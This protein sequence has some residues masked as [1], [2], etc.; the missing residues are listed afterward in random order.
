MEISPR[1]A[2]E[3]EKEREDKLEKQSNG[4]DRASFSKKFYLGL[5]SPLFQFLFPSPSSLITFLSPHSLSFSLSLNHDTYPPRN[6]EWF[7]EYDPKSQT[8]CHRLSL[9]LRYLR[10]HCDLYRRFP[11]RHSNFVAFQTDR[12]PDFEFYDL[13]KIFRY[14]VVSLFSLT[15]I[16]LTSVP[17]GVTIRF[18][19]TPRNSE[20]LWLS[21]S[22]KLQKILEVLILTW[23]SKIFNSKL[24]T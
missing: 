2:R 17:I 7:P 23:I 19:I 3:G 16:S 11:S 22:E 20:V 9:F 24:P 12:S 5:F 1:L 13:K 8:S 21:D 10:F 6:R 15:L 4:I 14:V 18:Q